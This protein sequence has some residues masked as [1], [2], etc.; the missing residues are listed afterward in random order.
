MGNRTKI[1]EEE[2]QDL[3]IWGW[4]RISSC[5]ELYSPLVKGEILNFKFMILEDAEKFL[6][7]NK[8]KLRPAQ[9]FNV[10]KVN[11][12]RLKEVLK[13]NVFLRTMVKNVKFK[14]FI[15]SDSM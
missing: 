7:E 5:R 11:F 8:E 12:Y 13:I 4:G 3:K 9:D 10:I 14:N 2:N 1:F 6:S 15:S